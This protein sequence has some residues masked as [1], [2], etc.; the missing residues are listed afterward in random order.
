MENKTTKPALPA[1]RYFKYA[2]GEIVLVVIGI[3]IALQ[4]N[5]WN[6]HKNEKT[7]IGNYYLKIHEEIIDTKKRSIRFNAALDKLNQHNYRSLE[8]I[9]LK[10]KDSLYLLKETL[11]AL[12]TVFTS[13]FTFPIINEFLNEGYLAKIKND[14][15]KS[16][17][18]LFSMAL[19]NLNTSDEY[20]NNQY[21]TSIEPFFYN[22]INYAE[23][24]YAGTDNDELLK[25]GGP[26]TNYGQFYDNL[27]LWNLLT[28]KIETT[29]SLKSHID[30]LYN[31]LENIDKELQNEL[32]K[33]D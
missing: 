26:T 14:S 33:N 24:V 13:N 11:G 9:N 28:F 7:E 30:I 27:E 4:I 6:N 25:K 2:I 15:L 31:I 5:N 23:V 32:S 12:G 18:Q 21:Y 1:G 19:N 8:I 10:N 29:N 3:L 17:F 22:T 20:V 16:G